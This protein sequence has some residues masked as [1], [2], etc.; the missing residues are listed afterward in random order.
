MFPSWCSER[1][2]M[3]MGQHGL[4]TSPISC[5]QGKRA[6]ESLVMQHEDLTQPCRQ[7]RT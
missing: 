6:C 4:K 5:Y 7:T 2:E 3:G 1:T